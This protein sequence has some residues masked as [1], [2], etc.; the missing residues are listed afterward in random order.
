MEAIELIVFFA[1]LILAVLIGYCLVMGV[2]FL[3]FQLW[4]SIK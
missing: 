3:I 1:L 4:E 2:S